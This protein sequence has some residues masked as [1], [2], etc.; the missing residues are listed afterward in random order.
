LSAQRLAGQQAQISNSFY[1]PHALDYRCTKEPQCIEKAI[2]VAA[3][4]TKLAFA[5]KGFNGITGA[6]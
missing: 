1:A 2:S 3:F 4:I 5:V 6:G